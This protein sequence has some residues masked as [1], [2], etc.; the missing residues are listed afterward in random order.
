MY[1]SRE[2]VVKGGNRN[3]ASQKAKENAPCNAHEY[4]STFC[5]FFFFSITTLEKEITK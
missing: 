2:R 5:F 1:T 4:F 3:P